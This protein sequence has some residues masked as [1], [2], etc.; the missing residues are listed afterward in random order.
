VRQIQLRKHY[1][2][3]YFRLVITIK[4]VYANLYLIITNFYT[5]LK[6]QVKVSHGMNS[7]AFT[8][9]TM[10]DHERLVNHSAVIRFDYKLT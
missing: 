4:R 5:E 7:P 10:F 3:F 8:L 6:P 2:L 1:S 9:Y